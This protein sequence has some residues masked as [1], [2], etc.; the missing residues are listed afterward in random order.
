MQHRF[1]VQVQR[2]SFLLSTTLVVGCSDDAQKM[3][4]TTDTGE[5]STM[6]DESTNDSTSETDTTWVQDCENDIRFA[7]PL[8]EAD[9]RKQANL[10]TG[11]LT[12]EN[13]AGILDA[14]VDGA[15][16]LEGLQC[17]PWLES[18]ISKQGTIVDLSPLRDLKELYWVDISNN[19]VR[20]ISPISR[21]DVPSRDSLKFVLSGN[22]IQSI[23]EFF[24]PGKPGMC[25]Y[26]HLVD[27]PGPA[28]DKDIVVQRFCDEGWPVIWSSSLIENSEFSCGI[29]VCPH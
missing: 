25:S 20:D 9:I 17:M 11:K 4:S 16:S 15:S 23:D 1:M 22:P 3:E 8:I 10:P 19:Q 12:R 7:D 28:S 21:P 5:S 14:G 29:F 6:Q 24:L 27:Y 18:V 2:L 13:L 26:F